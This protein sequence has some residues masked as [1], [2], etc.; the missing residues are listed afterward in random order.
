MSNQDGH[1]AHLRRTST[2]NLSQPRDAVDWALLQ[3]L[4][5]RFLE[6]IVQLAR[7]A[8]EHAP[9]AVT[10]NRAL[11]C[12]LD[13]AARKSIANSR[14]LLL[15]IN[16]ADP[17][18]WIEAA[19]NRPVG[20]KES[21]NGYVPLEVARELTREVMTLAWI[22]AREDQV[23]AIIF[24]GMAPRVAGLF[25]SFSPS[26]LEYY[27]ARYPQYLRLRFDDRSLYWRMHLRA[28]GR[29]QVSAAPRLLDDSQQ[30]LL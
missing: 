14:M 25:A 6:V 11:W 15:D 29:S 17:T 26:D 2:R 4:N 24:F 20:R 18:W 12:D 13:I 7:M 22:G 9:S 16:F 10:S 28:A 19:E 8:P 21:A 1:R 27:S 23:Q 30:S 3:T 5:E